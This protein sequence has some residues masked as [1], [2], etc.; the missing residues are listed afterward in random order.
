MSFVKW[1]DEHVPRPTN[2][3]ASVVVLEGE[4]VPDEVLHIG[5]DGVTHYHPEHT[6]RRDRR[7]SCET[8]SDCGYILQAEWR[9]CPNCGAR[10][11]E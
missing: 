4:R 11:E 10:I 8:C 1:H 2:Q 5:P 3:K 7:P 9:H 6:C